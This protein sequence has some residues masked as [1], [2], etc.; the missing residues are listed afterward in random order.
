[1]FLFRARVPALA[2]CVALLA[3]PGLAGDE[4]LSVDARKELSASEKATPRCRTQIINGVKES[5][6]GD[7][8]LQSQLLPKVL[9]AFDKQCGKPWYTGC[10]VI[11][12]TRGMCKVVE[13]D[14]ETRMDRGDALH[15]PKDFVD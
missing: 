11:Q 13:T 5:F 12:K 6:N 7:R 14:K 4:K 2:L 9:K 3:T 10:V 1:M 8:K 15:F